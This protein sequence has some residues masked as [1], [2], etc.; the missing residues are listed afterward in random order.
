MKKIALVLFVFA[1]GFV[2]FN[3]SIQAQ[4][5]AQQIAAIKDLVGKWDNVILPSLKK[6]TE[7]YDALKAEVDELKRNPPS[8][9]GGITL[10]DV[11]SLINQKAVTMNGPTLRA[12][13]KTD[14]EAQ[15]KADTLTAEVDRKIAKA[16]A[17]GLAEGTKI[18]EAMKAEF[19]KQITDAKAAGLAEGVKA[20][21]AM[22]ADLEAEIS[23]RKAGD[24]AVIAEIPTCKQ[25][26][27]DLGKFLSDKGYL[28]KSDGDAAY[29][30]K[31]TGQGAAEG[32]RADL[33]TKIATK[34]DGDTLDQLAGKVDKTRNAVAVL[35]IGGHFGADKEAARKIL[36]ISE[37]D[38]K[39]IAKK[40]K[41]LGL[42]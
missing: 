33:A 14:T 11:T 29:D 7:N 27:D 42:K 17:E 19:E 32:V 41:E 1:V 24:E 35:A 36:G 37:E 23:D 6:L 9:S 31:G 40:A 2:G 5:D 39:K 21:E 8:N 28:T 15:K 30:P 16:K 20:L 26:S 4:T 3:N 22:K 10:D 18:L 25:L 12:L 38:A 34:A 13:K